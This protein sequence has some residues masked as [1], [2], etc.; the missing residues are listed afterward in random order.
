MRAW[1]ALLLAP[2]T[3]LAQQSAWLSLVVHACQQQTTLALHLVWCASLALIGAFTGAAGLAWRN[4]L[5][6]NPL[7]PTARPAPETSRSRVKRFV[8]I[9]GTLVGMLSALVALFMWMPVWALGPCMS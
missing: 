1:P 6:T 5:A 2:L 7:A 4:A 8:A 3:A 9:A